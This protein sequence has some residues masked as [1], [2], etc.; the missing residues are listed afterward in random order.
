MAAVATAQT[1]FRKL[2]YAEALQAAK[3]E[4]KQVFVDFFTTWCGPCKLMAREVFPTKTV[5]DYMNAHFVSLQIDAEK[6]EGV[7][8]A[9][10]FKVRAYPT[11]VIINADD[12]EA[13]RT[14][15][16]RPAD[17]FVSE[18]ERAL[19][20]EMTPGKIRAR[21][22]GGDRSAEAVK[23]YAALLRDE[24]GQ[25]RMTHEQ[26]KAKSDSI[27][28]LVMGYFNGLSDQQKVAPE[29]GFIYRTYAD[30]SESPAGA[31]FIA[32]R[33]RFGDTHEVDSMVKNYFFATTYRYLSCEKPY[34][35]AKVKALADGIAK[36]GAN[37]DGS[38]TPALRIMDKMGGD[39][40]A[41]F[42]TVTKEFK[43]LSETFQAAIIGGLCDHYQT[44]DEATRKAAARVI[45][46]QLPD[47]SLQVMYSVVLDLGKLEGRGH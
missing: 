32:N 43:N 40:K 45:R 38:F 2:T 11:F 6:G 39:D 22:E 47:M 15:G 24:L 20:P 16:Y 28:T 7:A 27:T 19:N 29:N 46:Q 14:E 21:Y 8:L 23:N 9:Q 44:A 18:L 26:Y 12:T 37:A 35:A 30:D 25:T 41:L 1:D 33:K 13:A 10:R 36:N 4:R 17:Q 34:D 3:A 31:Y 5:G 42:A